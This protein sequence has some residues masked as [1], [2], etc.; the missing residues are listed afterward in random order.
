MVYSTLA[1]PLLKY[2]LLSLALDSL[3]VRRK[4]RS[5]MFAQKFLFIYF[6]LFVLAE[7]GETCIISRGQDN[8]WK[9]TS[10]SSQ[11]LQTVME[12]SKINLAL[13]PIEQLREDL[14]T[15]FV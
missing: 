7:D 12:N 9:H 8:V 14:N 1:I 11:W 13:N 5:L 4:L 3:I 10:E 15:T 6:C 2:E